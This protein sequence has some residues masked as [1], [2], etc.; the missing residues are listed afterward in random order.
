M[1]EDIVERLRTYA[2]ETEGEDLIYKAADEIERLRAEV[3]KFAAIRETHAIVPREPTEAMV[4]A[5]W[6]GRS[7]SADCWRTGYKAMIAAAEEGSIVIPMDPEA[8][9]EGEG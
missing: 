4:E 9:A 1:T 6:V 7:G 3:T 2:D 5:G 8:T